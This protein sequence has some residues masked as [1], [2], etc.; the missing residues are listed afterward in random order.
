MRDVSRAELFRKIICFC[1]INGYDYKYILSM[2]S[3]QYRAWFE[4][5][6][7]QVIDAVDYK[8]NTGISLDDWRDYIWDDPI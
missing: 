8:L 4:H 6:T 5:V 2:D 7:N 1:V 3:G